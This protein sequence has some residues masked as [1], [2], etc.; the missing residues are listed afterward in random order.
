MTPRFRGTFFSSLPLRGRGVESAA[1]FAGGSD[2]DFFMVGGRVQ[3]V[4][5]DG[6]SATFASGLFAG[7]M[8]QKAA[9]AAGFT[10]WR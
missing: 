8:F 5:A 3:A 9:A 1:D 7:V 2:D 4:F 10:N 6:R